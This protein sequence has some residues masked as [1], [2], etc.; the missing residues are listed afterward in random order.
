MGKETL[1]MS[2]ITIPGGKPIN[3]IVKLGV[4]LMVMASMLGLSGCTEL[5]SSKPKEVQLAEKMLKEKYNEEFVV[6]SIGGRW[7][8]LTNSTFAVVC[9]PA[10]NPDLKFK[11][12]VEKNGAYM[13]DEYVS[14]RVSTLIE[15]AL[16]KS[17][18][19]T[20]NKFVLKV[21]AGSKSIDSDNSS[22]S[23]EEFLKEKPNEKFVVDVIIDKNSLDGVSG[24]TLYSS[25]NSMLDT[26]PKLSGAI[27]VYFVTDDILQSSKN[28][29]KEHANTDSEFDDILK[30]SSSI[31]SQFGDGVLNMSQEEFEAKFR[32]I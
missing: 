1:K 16:V 12:E 8:T 20:V 2:K 5:G 10:D 7:G 29:L 18:K 6:Y 26:V 27:E 13:H 32:G 25:L 19:D 11:A 15:E 28:Y 14:R 22:M 30:N 23:I 17:L 9:S 31:Y 3:K 21:S 4:I 24:K